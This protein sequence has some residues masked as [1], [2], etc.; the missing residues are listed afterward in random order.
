MRLFE[1]VADAYIKSPTFHK[2]AQNTK[3]I[4]L[5]GLVTAISRFETM[6]ITYIDRPMV[7]DFRD[8]LYDSPGK[9][10]IALG[11]LSNVLK[12]AFDHGWVTANVAFS[13]GDLPPSVPHK[14][15]SM[16][17]VNGFLSTAPSHLYVAVLLAV[18]TGQRRSDL[19]KIQW[20]DYDGR[21]IYVKQKKTGKELHIPVHPI[22]KDH[23]DRLLLGKHDQLHA[24]T[25]LRTVTGERWQ[26]D[27]LRKAVLA[28]CRKIGLEGR[29]I[30]GLR[31]TTASI[32]A[33]MGCNVLQIMAITGHSSVK[34]VMRYIEEVEQRKLA[35]EA[36]RKWSGG[37]DEAD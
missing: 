4:Y 26:A 13:I 9:C 36:M 6:P 20:S 30:H 8:Q 16:E 10:K 14:R 18:Y 35:G 23:I 3:R 19:V 21:T 33:E 25:I 24:G 11:A 7:I 31:K 15:W 1:D 27:Y 37:N 2:L 32:L 5:D 12:Y 17:E 29:T 22:L 28:H 34:E